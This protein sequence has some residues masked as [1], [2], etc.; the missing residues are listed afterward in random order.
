MYWLPSVPGD[1]VA[2]LV[3]D[4]V[5]EAVPVSS[6]HEPTVVNCSSV[7]E[8]PLRSTRAIRPL[9]LIAHVLP[10]PSTGHVV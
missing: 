3:I 2:E 10:R 8:L 1:T 9:E 7:T 5:A 6:I 4:A